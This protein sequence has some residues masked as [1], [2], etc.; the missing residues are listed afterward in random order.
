M[1]AE[2]RGPMRYPRLIAGPA[3]ALACVSL[4]ALSSGDASAQWVPGFPQFQPVF[5]VKLCNDL[6]P[7]FNGPDELEGGGGSCVPD[8]APGAHPDITFSFTVP[9][10]HMNYD[11]SY[12]VVAG[13]A[14][15]TRL[16]GS[17]IGGPNPDGTGAPAGGLEA[18]I[19]L[20]WAA[21]IC[22]DASFPDFIWWEA[23]YSIT[24]TVACQ[25]E[26]TSNRWSNMAIDGGDAFSG[27][28]DRNSPIVT[29]FPDCTVK[30]FDPDGD[31]LDTDGN[32]A[33]IGDQP[34]QPRARFAGLTHVPPGSGNWQMLQNIEFDPGDL[35]A[36]FLANPNTTK[37]PY[38]KLDASLGY[39]NVIQL[40]D[41]TTVI[42]QPNP[43]S[44]FCTILAIKG[45]LKG[46]IDT[47][48]NG[49]LDT[50]RVTS[51]VTS[52]SHQVQ[53]RTQSYRD[54]DGDGIENN[55]DT[56]VWQANTAS[57]DP[58]ANS[59][60]DNDMLDSVCDPTPGVKNDDQDGDSYLNSQDWCPQNSNPGNTETD[61]EN[62][63]WYNVSAPDGG[64][65]QDSIGDDC[66]AKGYNAE[67]N[68]DGGASG[69]CNDGIDNGGADGADADDSDCA[70]GGGG[71]DNVSDGLFFNA[72]HVDS[73]CITGSDK[74]DADGDGWCND[75]DP[76]DGDAYDPGQMTH[77]KIDS[78]GAPN[79]DSDSDGYSNLTEWSRIGTDP[80]NDC[81][82]FSGEH[83][84][85]PPDMNDNQSVGLTDFL[86]TLDSDADTVP[87]AGFK[88][89]FNTDMDG[90]PNEGDGVYHP[91]FD[92]EYVNSA[93]GGDPDINLL[94]LLPFKQVFYQS[95]T[96]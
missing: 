60:P 64:P 74:V 92:L 65:R 79:L 14:N 21:N 85:W 94:D 5:D 77:V 28:A 73:V 43:I 39:I 45:M 78:A 80:A 18:T 72:L 70:V 37:H 13:G 87:D 36:A 32:P 23:E 15:E 67:G 25:G 58:Y 38:T 66:D 27:Q 48:N 42:L 2:G 24:D 91:R 75:K 46:Q 8:T 7:T 10:G 17:Q 93:P 4:A 20:G 56:C 83:D 3:L 68:E 54:A 59:G 26:S 62:N 44:D 95:C 61:N 22:N 52:G 96:P 35:Q 16:D 86:L 11:Q 1:N 30:M 63:Q 19:T 6:K 34:V 84:A 53:L 76:N 29:K 50:N 41:P 71:G 40:N 81:P 82:L 57:E 12:F 88:N 55:F 89:S 90:T 9:Q 33:T 51:P 31:G 49:S 47:D 69:D